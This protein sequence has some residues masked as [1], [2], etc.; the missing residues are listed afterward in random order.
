MKTL[1]V[2]FTS[3]I[4]FNGAYTQAFIGGEV[5]NG[6]D[7]IRCSSLPSGESEGLYFLDYLLARPLDPPQGLLD[8]NDSIDRIVGFL[9]SR[10]P[11]LAGSLLEFKSWIGQSSLLGPYVWSPVHYGLVDIKDEN[12]VE[13]LPP[14]CGAQWQQAV[15]RS[16]I[17]S[18]IQFKYDIDVFSELQDSALQFSML[19]V[20]EWLWQFADNAQQVRLANQ[21]LHSL[22]TANLSAYQLNHFF[23]D[24]GLRIPSIKHRHATV[25]QVDISAAGKPVQN[26]FRVR[27][28]VE[29]PILVNYKNLSD[30]PIEVRHDFADH[31]VDQNS[32]VIAPGETYEELIEAPAMLFLYDRTAV[33]P[34]VS[35]VTVTR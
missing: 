29:H 32:Y 1:I 17:G 26:T 8:E 31:Q 10:N 24:L 7:V 20:H 28:P 21:F 9:R 25:L 18:K 12:V 23:R 2:L 30:R 4:I 11:D 35:T 16:K 33:A 15:V 5:G 13:L 22:S 27:S 14:T 6:G 19:L 3:L 34:H